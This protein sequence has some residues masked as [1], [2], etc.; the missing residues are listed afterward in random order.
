MRNR[1]AKSSTSAP[2]APSPAPIRPATWSSLTE[3]TPS[4]E[5][6]PRHVVIGALDGS[7][8]HHT[9]A[10]TLGTA[11][12]EG[13]RARGARYNSAVRYLA[14]AK[15]ATIIVLVSEDGMINVLP[16]LQPRITRAAIERALETY[17]RLTTSD[18]DAEMRANALERLEQLRF[19]L[20]A[21]QCALINELERA[22]QERRLAEGGIMITGSAF[23]PDPAMN[24]SYFL[25]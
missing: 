24:D 9:Q 14:S 10:R 4:G 5:G 3:K 12:A 15:P 2:S 6:R 22:Y 20:N 8:P 11:T 23:K 25:D 17:Q 7:D 19:Y 1:T 13:D 21:E 18:D 16:R